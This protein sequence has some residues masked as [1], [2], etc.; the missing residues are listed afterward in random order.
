MIELGAERSQTGFDVAQAFAPRQLSKSHDQELFVRWQRANTVI[1]AVT[2]DASVEFV[3]GQAV[4]QL[5]EN[6]AS[7][8][9]RVQPPSGGTK[10]CKKAFLN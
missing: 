2:L 3:F 10:P 6:G 1:A 7:F 9:H 8:V 5:G 4:Q